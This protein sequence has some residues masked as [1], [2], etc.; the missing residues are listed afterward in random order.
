MIKN[1]KIVITGASEGLGKAIA[2]LLSEN[3]AQ[4]I[5][6]ARSKNNLDAV[7]KT[8]KKQGGKATIF[9]CDISSLSEV[10][11][12]VAQIIKEIGVPDILINNAGIWIHNVLEQKNPAKRQE[13]FD[14]NAVGTIQLTE[15]FL[16]FLKKKNTGHILNIISTSGTQDT[17]QGDNKFWKTYGATKWA[18]SGYTNALQSEL[19]QTGI[20]VTGFFPGDIDTNLYAKAG[21]KELVQQSWMMQTKDIA[22]IILFILTRPEDVSIDKMVVTKKFSY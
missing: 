1:K 17:L 15:E 18:V 2:L 9:V 13:A 7:S 20:K 14:V 8:I 5:L 19:Q 10:K 22:E 3:G 6:L 16:P 21:E 12:T 4:V 11:K